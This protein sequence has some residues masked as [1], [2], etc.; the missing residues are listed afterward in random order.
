MGLTPILGVTALLALVPLSSASAIS[1]CPLI[2]D[3]QGDASAPPAVSSGANFLFKDEPAY[4]IVSADIASDRKV[5][6]MV[7]RVEK[8]ANKAAGSPLGI[9]WRFDFTA[10]QNTLFAEVVSDSNDW[11]QKQGVS[12]YIGYV[13]GTS[14]YIKPTRAYLDMRHNE[15][16]IRV[17]VGDYGTYAPSIG[18][19]LTNLIAS[20]GRWYDVPGFTYS[21]TVDWAR[22]DNTYILGRKTCI[23]A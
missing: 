14:H 3:Q 1:K 9:E 7:I 21:E 20:A 12:A 23:K 16:R 17:P 5:I 2:T 6:N 10:G 11:G 8:L 4:D 22:T 13:D 19:R 18:T 15:I